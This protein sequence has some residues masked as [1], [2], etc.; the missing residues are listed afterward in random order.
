MKK[1]KIEVEE[2]LQKVIEVEAE[3]AEEAI[4]NVREKYYNDELELDYMDLMD[5]E[6]REF[7]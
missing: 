2:V 5:V 4:K 1:Y 7:E 6:F 3:S